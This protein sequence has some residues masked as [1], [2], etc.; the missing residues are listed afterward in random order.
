MMHKNP[1][2]KV[3]MDNICLSLHGKTN[4]EKTESESETETNNL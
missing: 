4:E 2:R 3:T 1:Q